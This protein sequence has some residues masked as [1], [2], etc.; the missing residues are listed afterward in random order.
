[1]A[2]MAEHGSRTVARGERQGLAKLKQDQV[3]AIRAELQ[4]GRKR[5]DVA[6]RYGMSEGA[7]YAIEMRHTW[8]WL[9]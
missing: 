5:K 8:A 6:E 7:I 4:S 9:E 2:D 3:R 1:M